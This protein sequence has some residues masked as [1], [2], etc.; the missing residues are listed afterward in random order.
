MHAQVVLAGGASAGARAGVLAALDAW[1]GAGDN[2]I[3]LFQAAGRPL[4][5][6]GLYALPVRP[7][8]PRNPR[9]AIEP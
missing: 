4:C 1:Q 7:K 8:L 3:V 6:R 9:P 2:L 5:F